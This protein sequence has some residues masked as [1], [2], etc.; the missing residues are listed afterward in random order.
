MEF[1]KVPKNIHEFWTQKRK[2]L[3]CVN[4]LTQTF[5]LNSCLSE[6]SW[7]HCDCSLRDSLFFLLTGY[8]YVLTLKFKDLAP[9]TR[10]SVSPSLLICSVKL[11]D[12]RNADV[13]IGA[14]KSNF[15]ILINLRFSWNFCVWFFWSLDPPEVPQN[16]SCQ[17]NLTRTLT[18]TCSWD[19][20]QSQTYLPTSYSVHSETR[21]EQKEI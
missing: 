13:N 11:L 17:A 7:G 12:Y 15:C 10:S 6:R 8:F 3:I 18:L 9:K 14:T 20:G 16:L 4:K 21:S 1:E 2:K 19:P 5:F